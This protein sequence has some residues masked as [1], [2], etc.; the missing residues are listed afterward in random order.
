[1]STS[2]PSD[3][4]GDQSGSKV[5]ARTNKIAIY[6]RSYTRDSSY[7]DMQEQRLR[8]LVE[9]RNRHYPF[10]EVVEVFRDSGHVFGAFN[11]SALTQMLRAIRKRRMTLVLVP[12][13]RDLATLPRDLFRLLRFFD[14]HRCGLRSLGEYLLFEDLRVDDEPASTRTSEEPSF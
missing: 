5:P 10:G 9:S 7:A 14:R 4:P 11:R 12:E 1:M 3:L 6:L 2:N 8:E 13:F